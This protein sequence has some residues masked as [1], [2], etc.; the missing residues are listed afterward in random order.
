MALVA[1]IRRLTLTIAA[2]G[3]LTAP[4]LAGQ[5]MTPGSDDALARS[6]NTPSTECTTPATGAAS[7]NA[8]T[9]VGPG[10][11]CYGPHSTP[12]C[13]GTTPCTR[14]SELRSTASATPKPSRQEQPARSHQRNAAT[15]NLSRT[16]RQAPQRSKVNVRNLPATPGMG[17]LLRVGSTAGREISWIDLGV[18][19]AP[20][21]TRGGRAPPRGPTLATSPPAALP[22][23]PPQAAPL[24][25]CPPSPGTAPLDPDPDP[26]ESRHL[27]EARDTRAALLVRSSRTGD[28]FEPR[29][30]ASTLAAVSVPLPWGRRD[31]VRPRAGRSESATVRWLSRLSGGSAT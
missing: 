8:R 27:R 29:D 26:T 4:V 30:A 20:W 23:A 15:T 1:R 17:T 10:E 16:S 18:P 12:A 3:A 2:L 5:R 7:R 31:A 14:P 21:L 25:V 6:R 9:S 19:S 24:R 22:A 28:A 11:D 13:T